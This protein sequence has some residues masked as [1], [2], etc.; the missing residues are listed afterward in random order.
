[1]IGGLGGD[2]GGIQH[3]APAGSPL[4]PERANRHG[5][6]MF[7]SSSI[8]FSPWHLSMAAI[9]TV[10]DDIK[11]RLIHSPAM[12]L[13]LL[14]RLFE[15]TT[16]SDTGSGNELQNRLETILEASSD[17]SN[18]GI[19]HFAKIFA[20]CHDRGFRQAFKD[21]WPSSNNQ[22]G[23]FSTAVDMGYRP[24]KT[25]AY[26]RWYGFDEPDR[27]KSLPGTVYFPWEEEIC[28]RLII[29]H[30]QTE[31][32]YDMWQ[33]WHW[34]GKL[35][36]PFSASSDEV[37]IFMGALNRV[38][39][40]SSLNVSTSRAALSGIQIGTGDGNSIQDLH[41]SLYGYAFGRYIKHS[42]I[43]TR[44]AAADWL[45]TNLGGPDLSVMALGLH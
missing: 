32:S 16:I 9:D 20:G 30:E 23:H 29:G 27:L 45:R 26:A 7:A 34:G 31:D 21:P 13:E 15:D 11:R 8:V 24:S 19:S 41:L 37:S 40:T 10:A 28:V 33:V 42:R 35:K 22:L 25:A 39:A 43:T 3:S 12:D 38:P 2:R 14:A 18:G 36:V 44:A 4:Q 5:T 17:G 6:L 1:M